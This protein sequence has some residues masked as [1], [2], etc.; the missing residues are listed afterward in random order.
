[1]EATAVK[2]G[3][4]RWYQ[5]RGMLE[6]QMEEAVDKGDMG[7][8]AVGGY[9]LEYVNSIIDAAE[10]GTPLLSTW[11]ANGPEIPSAM[12]I[13]VFCPP[14]MVLPFASVTGDADKETLATA[15][16]PEESCDLVRIS[17]YAVHAGLVPTPTMIVSMLEPCDAQSVLTE[18]WR[19]TTEWGTVPVFALDYPYGNTDEDYRYFAG[20]LKRMIAWLEEHSGQKMDYDRLREVCEETNRQYEIWAQISELQTSTPSPFG[21]FELDGL[22]FLT[23]HYSTGHPGLTALLGAMLQGAEEKVK[24]GIGSV[25]DERIRI[26]WPD[27]PGSQNPTFATWLADKYGAVVVA[28]HWGEGRVYT[29][30]DTSTVDSMLFGIARRSLNEVPMIRQGRGTFDQY[31][32]DLKRS[33]RDYHCDCVFYPGHRGHKDVIA[34]VGFIRETCRDLGVPLLTLTVS[35]NAWSGALEEEIKRRVDEFFEAHGWKPLS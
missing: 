18:L 23:Q 4:P 24:D 14:D 10:N 25:P 31:C 9:L 16:T 27:L 15:P 20:E 35:L 2:R 28:D 11:Y 1:M 22:A 34:S 33:V 21:S 19:E 30:I 32:E 17:A 5:Y 6:Q 3:L 26:Y 8:A 12:G 7:G 13:P 29:A